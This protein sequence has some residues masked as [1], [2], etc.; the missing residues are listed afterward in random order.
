MPAFALGLRHLRHRTFHDLRHLLA[1]LYARPLMLL[2]LF[3]RVRRVLCSLRF[4]ADSHN[5][6]LLRCARA[7]PPL[8]PHTPDLTPAPLPGTFTP[9]GHTATRWGK[10]RR[11]WWLRWNSCGWAAS[12]PLLLA[13]RPCVPLDMPPKQLAGCPACRK[14][15]GRTAALHEGRR[16]WAD[17]CRGARALVAR[18]S[19]LR[20]PG[21][22]TWR[23]PTGAWSMHVQG[24]HSQLGERDGRP[25]V[26]RRHGA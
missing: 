12:G 21:R 6:T 19:R 14:Q 25:S 9:R 3:I 26:R 16:D 17:H 24:L 23:G 15:N 18:L 10:R 1:T 13:D 7:A 8:A 5:R 4:A 22:S 11:R 2:D 20:L